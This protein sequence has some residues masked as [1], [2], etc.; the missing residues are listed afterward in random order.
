MGFR[1]S[2]IAALIALFLVGTAAPSRGEEQA[3]GPAALFA[4]NDPASTITLDHSPWTSLLQRSVL[5]VGRSRERLGSD[6]QRTFIES[7]ITFGN[8]SPS[9]FEGNRVFLHIY[10]K[11]VKLFLA[12]YQNGLQEV[13]SRV[14][15]AL[16]SRDEQL[17]FWLNLYNVTVMRGLSA[18]YPVSRLQNFRLGS[19]KFGNFWSEKQLT[20]EGVR[21]SLNDI[22]DILIENWRDPLVLYGLWQGAIGSPSL[23][24]EAFTAKNVYALLRTSAVEFVNSNRGFRAG[25]ST[26][27][28][29][30]IYQW[31][32]AAFADG[33]ALLA[34]LRSL[35]EPPFDAGLGNASAVK[36][37]LFDWNIADVM[38]G[39]LHSGRTNSFSAFIGSLS[40]DFGD[41]MKDVDGRQ[42][43]PPQ[44][45]QLMQGVVQY[46]ILPERNPTVTVIECP[47]GT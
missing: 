22:E 38:G 17:A 2:A 43:I 36:Y 42:G 25:T 4:A 28:V 15:L 23:P 30:L 33:Q 45:R 46:N 3:P 7:H 29:S 37:G 41:T 18:I 8:S 47:P 32:R 9:R 5:V 40:R 16:L 34:H 39:Q 31:G 21:L 11:D 44:M 10:D 6:Q 12:A 26:L 13:A 19:K 24:S 1:V 27:N 20:V 14:S 35:A